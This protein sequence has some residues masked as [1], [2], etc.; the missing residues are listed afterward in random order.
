M[1]RVILHVDMDAFFAAVEVLHRPGLAGK[2]LIIGADPKGGKGR[3][4]VSTCSYEAREFGIRS[5]MPISTAYR[6][7]PNGT[8]LSVNFDIYRDAS[9]H[10]MDIIRGFSIYFEQTSIDEAYLDITY[11][12]GPDNS[13]AGIA[14]ALKKNIMDVSGL[15]CSVGV[16]PTKVVAKIA[17]DHHKPNGITVVP[18]DQVRSFL[19]P[20]PVGKIPG[21]GKKTRKI[22]EGLGVSSIGE[23]AEMSPA[24]VIAELG[25]HGLNLHEFAHGR[26][27]RKVCTDR[28]IK[29]IGRE[30]TFDVDTTDKEQLQTTLVHLAQRT[31]EQLIDEHMLFKTITLKL[32]FHNFATINRSFSVQS[33]TN[34]KR[35]FIEA[36]LEL[37]NRHLEPNTPIRLVGI[38]LSNLSPVGGIQTTLEDFNLEL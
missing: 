38:R 26:D 9:S 4:V 3:G 33:P 20:Q 30:D 27:E 10:V 28:E 12:V 34:S 8:Y 24:K 19:N 35:V 7:C 37:L 16:G 18:L 36:T 5:A 22:L 31:H 29:S 2:P 25:A 13:P 6:L 15:S 1:E 32:R 21:V 17:S 11:L 23:L 14:V